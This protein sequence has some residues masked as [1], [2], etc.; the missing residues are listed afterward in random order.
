MDK[1]KMKMT[2]KNAYAVFRMIITFI[3]VTYFLA[4]AFFY[5]S[6]NLNTKRDVADGNTFYQKYGFDKEEWLF[7]LL[8]FSYYMSTTVNIIGYGELFPQSEIEKVFICFVMFVG[9][10]IAV[11]FMG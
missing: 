6:S 10:L 2:C 7:Y 3:M 4:C 5:V 11:S 9:Q 8:S 1:V